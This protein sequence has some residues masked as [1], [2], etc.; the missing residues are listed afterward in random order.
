M[1]KSER[2]ISA[3]VTDITVDGIFGIDFLKRGNVINLKTNTLHL[4]DENCTVSC[5]GTIGCYHDTT[6]ND[7]HSR[8]LM[9]DGE[10]VLVRLMKYYR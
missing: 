1:G 10:I 4:N 2:L 3:I 7:I 6:A 8:T 9:E 5:E